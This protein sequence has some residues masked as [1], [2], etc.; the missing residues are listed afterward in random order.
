MFIYTPKLYFSLN[1]ELAVNAQKSKRTKFPKDEI[2]TQC[3]D[4][5]TYLDFY[6]ALTLLISK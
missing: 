6:P 5:M 1:Y 4:S 2:I 3:K